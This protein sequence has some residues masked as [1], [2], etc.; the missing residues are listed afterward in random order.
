[1]SSETVS[2]ERLEQMRRDAQYGA[3]SPDVPEQFKKHGRD[4]VAII[5]ELQSL[6]SKPVASGVEVKPELL[7]AASSLQDIT[8]R[9]NELGVGLAKYPVGEIEAV[10]QFVSLAISAPIPKATAPVVSEPV[11][12]TEEMVERAAK[13]IVVELGTSPT[14]LFEIH[15]FTGSEPFDH[16]DAGGKRYIYSWRKQVA[17]AR[18]ALEAAMKEA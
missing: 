10:L 6:R 1:M 11:A 14:T 2:D 4:M 13:A 17:K 9:A 18:A 5:T 3:S 15:V 12:V 16:E 8:F 7:A